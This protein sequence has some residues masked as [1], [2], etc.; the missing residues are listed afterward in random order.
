MILNNNAN[1][2]ETLDFSVSLSAKVST[3]T[4]WTREY[5]SLDPSSSD[6]FL[7]ILTLTLLGKFL[8]PWFQMN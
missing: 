6:L 8:I 1:Q 4:C 3:L 7:E 5:H 2:A